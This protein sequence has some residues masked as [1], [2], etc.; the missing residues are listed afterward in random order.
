VTRHSIP[1]K[2]SSI[3]KNNDL[4]SYE[5]LNNSS[6]SFFLKKKTEAETRRYM[7]KF[8]ELAQNTIL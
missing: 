2:V 7:A 8:D 4:Q 3:R 6:E 1:S 5:F